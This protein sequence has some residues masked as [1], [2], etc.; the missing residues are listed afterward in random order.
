MNR[1]GLTTNSTNISIS[2]I[3]GNSHSLNKICQILACSINNKFKLSLSCLVVPEI[4]H[5]F[6]NVKINFEQL[7]IPNNMMLADPNFFEPNKI[8]LLIGASHYFSL[9]CQQQINLG[10]RMPVL[11]ETKLGWIISGE[12]KCNLIMNKNKICNLAL[13]QNNELIKGV[14][15]FWSIEEFSNNKKIH[16]AEEI[17]CENNFINTT[18]RN[19]NGR[20][21][22]TIPFKESPETLGCSKYSTFRQYVNMKKR[23][24]RDSN[25]YEM[26]KQFMN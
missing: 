21:I 13:E 22:V 19:I 14:E 18:R 26:Y 9:F 16:S 3:D 20:F 7:N 12:V 15:K 8:D 5:I 2:G 4:N 1:L 24:L 6:P 23:L 17:A 11:Q 10:K 25:M